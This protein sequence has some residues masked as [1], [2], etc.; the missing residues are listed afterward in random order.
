MAGKKK[1]SN[2]K[3]VGLRCYEPNFDKY[4]EKMSE[5]KNNSQKFR[6]RLRKASKISDSTLNQRFTV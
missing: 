3:Q 2:E 5:I 4:D 1:M 6:K